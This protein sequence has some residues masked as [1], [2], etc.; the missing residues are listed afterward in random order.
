VYVYVYVVKIREM[1]EKRNIELFGIK[2][3]CNRTSEKGWKGVASDEVAI[4]SYHVDDRN[5]MATQFNGMKWNGVHYGHYGFRVLIHSEHRPINKMLRDI[6]F[7]TRYTVVVLRGILRMFSSQ[8]ESTFT[9]ILQNIKMQFAEAQLEKFV[10]KMEI[11]DVHKKHGGVRTNTRGEKV[12]FVL[13]PSNDIASEAV[14]F[15]S[16]IAYKI[17]LDNTWRAEQG[18]ITL[19]YLEALPV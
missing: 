1:L 11:K 15:L 6:I 2:R 5:Y 12:C 13:F 16:K 8:R 3:L 10:K 7:G 14:K 4:R 19:P 17:K 18:M 9:A